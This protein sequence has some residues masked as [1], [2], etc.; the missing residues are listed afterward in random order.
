M[1]T[2]LLTTQEFSDQQL[3][4]IILRS[5]LPDTVLD[6]Y[7]FGSDQFEVIS[8][9][10]YW[11]ESRQQIAVP[12]VACDSQRV[13]ELADKSGFRLDSCDGLDRPPQRLC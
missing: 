8:M 10:A 5:K 7:I 9:G 6:V 2:G 13:L 3:L 12:L 1:V 11:L 4:S